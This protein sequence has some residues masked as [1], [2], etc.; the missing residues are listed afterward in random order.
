MSET[1]FGP[2]QIG[3]C[4]FC[5]RDIPRD[6]FG[7]GCALCALDKTAERADQLQAENRRL[8]DALTQLVRVNEDRW[9]TVDATDR[10]FSRALDAAEAALEETEEEP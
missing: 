3:R 7:G 4:A 6:W 2:G 9:S 10:A 5:G 1:I 8:R